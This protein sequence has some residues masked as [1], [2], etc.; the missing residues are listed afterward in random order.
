LNPTWSGTPAALAA[1]MAR[2]AS[3]NVSAIGFSQK[4]ALPAPA[5]VSIRSAWIDG[6]AAMTTASIDESSITSAGSGVAYAPPSDDATRSAV[7]S[8]GSATA[9]S[10]ASAT[11]RAR[12]SA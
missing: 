3:A 12:L 11:R 6:G 1:S 8:A 2:S 4:T 7:S 9:A 5:A 10:S